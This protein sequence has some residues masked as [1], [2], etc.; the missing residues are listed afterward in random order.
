LQLYN[1]QKNH[2][3]P[4]KVQVISYT[5]T[6]PNYPSASLL[7]QSEPKFLLKPTGALNVP[8]TLYCPT[9]TTSS[10]AKLASFLVFERGK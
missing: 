1:E 5:I 8:L 7:I 4:F 6:A 10:T 9:L 2:N 3:D